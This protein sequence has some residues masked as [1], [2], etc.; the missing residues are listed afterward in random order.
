MVAADAS[1]TM[2][3]PANAMPGRSRSRSALTALACF[4]NA[5][6]PKREERLAWFEGPWKDTPLVLEMWFSLQATSRLSGT[7]DRVH[8]SPDTAG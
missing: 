3:G 8:K 1:S 6:A 5:R 2:V 4:A 7:L